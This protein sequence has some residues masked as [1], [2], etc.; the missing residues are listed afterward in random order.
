MKWVVSKESGGAELI[1]AENYVAAV[2]SVPG[3]QSARLAQYIDKVRFGL[4]K[5]ETSE[6]PEKVPEKDTPP[7]DDV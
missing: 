6:E 5:E 7:Y 2:A 4:I 3:G 1:D